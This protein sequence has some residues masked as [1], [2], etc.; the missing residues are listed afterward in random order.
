MLLLV[1]E[2]GALQYVPTE[3]INIFE[4]RPGARWVGEKS[5]PVPVLAEPQVV[6]NVGQLL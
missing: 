2:R 6:R 3:M 4:Q 1:E 5:V